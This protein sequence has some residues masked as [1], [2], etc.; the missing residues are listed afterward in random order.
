[1]V[2]VGSDGQWRAFAAVLGDATIA[3]HAGWATNAGRVSDREACVAAVAAVLAQR[4][5]EQWLAA[6]TAAGIP[7]GRV[8]SVEEAVTDLGGDARLG[9]PS[10]V[11]GAFHRAPPALGADTERVR[12]L[13]WAAFDE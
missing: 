10:S 8:R 1:M 4:P 3:A 13:G 12:Q 2:A 11:G 9:M 7:C 5:A 6:L